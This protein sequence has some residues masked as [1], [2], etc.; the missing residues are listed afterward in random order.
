L[1]PVPLLAL[2]VP[3]LVDGFVM[4]LISY[5]PLVLCSHIPF[6]LLSLRFLLPQLCSSS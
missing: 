1:V 5:V 2:L 6:S 3:L 4:P